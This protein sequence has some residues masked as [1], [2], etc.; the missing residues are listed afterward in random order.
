MSTPPLPEATAVDTLPEGTWRVDPTASTLTFSARG[1]FGLIPVKGT[2]Q[3]YEGELDIHGADVHGELRIQA[4]TLSTKNKK[5]DTHLR[6]ADFFHVAE[7]PTV[8]FSLLELTP[9]ADGGLQLNGALK[10][11]ENQLALQAPVT[12]TR[13]GD[14]RLQLETNVSV[15]RAAAGV[16]WSK[17]GMIQGKAHLGAS[18]VLVRS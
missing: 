11:R 14:D 16:G 13:L 18:I 4:E 15:D 17:M 9:S 5:R 2:F 8:T 10:I 6:S 7:H 1:T 3:A 12:A